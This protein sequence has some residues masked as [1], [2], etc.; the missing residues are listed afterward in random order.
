MLYKDLGGVPIFENIASEFTSKNLQFL[1]PIMMLI[2]YFIA[3]NIVLIVP[4]TIK[5]LKN[6][7]KN[8]TK[9]KQKTLQDTKSSVII[10]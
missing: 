8:K 7:S 2:L 4:L 5:K 6:L 1:N 10:H 3:F 9:N